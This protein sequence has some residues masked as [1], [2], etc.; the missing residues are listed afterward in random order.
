MRNVK[1]DR[2]HDS[3]TARTVV[4]VEDDA[5]IGRLIEFHLRLAGFGIRRFTAA[6][7]VVREAE[8]APPVLFLLDL[9][10]PGTDGF[11]LS[12]WIRKNESLK[13]IP[14]IVLTARTGRADRELAFE[15]G[16]DD[17]VTKPLSPSDLIMRVRKLCEQV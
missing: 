11:E 17:Y 15:V 10:L 12:R 8:N 3:N 9:M 1:R 4:L 13:Q 5:D 14:I 16:A 2:A 6:T 7:N